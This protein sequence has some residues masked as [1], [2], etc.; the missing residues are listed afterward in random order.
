MHVRTL[1]L[2]L[3][4]IFDA[5]Y[6]EGHVTRA[7][8]KLYLSQ[9]AVSHALTRLRQTLKDELFI[10]VPG[11]VR[12]T[13]RALELAPAIHDA[14]S[15]LEQALNPPEFDP[16]KSKR[17]FRIATHDYLTTV[18]MADLAKMLVRAAPGVSIRV[19]PTEGRAFE[20]LDNQNV[21]IAV[22]AF[23][24]I[25]E[26]FESTTLFRDHYV[27]VMAKNH[28]LAKSKLQVSDFV[29]ARHLLISPR[30]DE[31]GWVDD[32]LAVRKQSRHVA[33]IINTFSPAGKIV[34]QSDLILTVPER[35]AFKLQQS[36]SLVTKP[37]PI[38]PPDAFMETQVIWHR[39]LGQ[40]PALIWLAD[41]LKQVMNC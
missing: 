20:L 12:P 6:S 1:D 15:A 26:R 38:K 16:K 2:N 22:S 27:C 40:H 4:K 9:P 31:K 33:M 14:L 13:K 24:D 23:G 25:P 5:V 36:S 18:L 7:A 30:G 17:I 37:C 32:K 10:K 41:T 34:Q 19:R 3:L 28:K 39:R 29:K 11:G 8:E 35:I 21:D